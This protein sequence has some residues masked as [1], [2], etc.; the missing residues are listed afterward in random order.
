MTPPHDDDIFVSEPRPFAVSA[1]TAASAAG[2]GEAVGSAAALDEAHHDDAFADDGHDHPHGHHDDYED[3]YEYEELP[4]EGRIPRWVGVLLVFALMAGAV[5]G[6]AW[7]WYQRQVNPPGAPGETVTVVVPTGSSTS[8]IGAILESEG[9]ISNSTIFGFYAGRKDAG[10]F[11]AGTYEMQTNSDFDLALA[12]LAAGPVAPVVAK[13]DKVSI[14]EG[15]TARALLARISSQVP[16]YTAADLD[17]ALADGNVTTTLRPEGQTSWEGMLFPAT[18]EVEDDTSAPNLLNQLADEM[19]VRVAGLDPEAAKATISAR[20]GVQVSTYDLLTVASLVQA[21]AGNADEAAKIATVIYNRLGQGWALGID[22]T[23]KY[24]ADLEGTSIDFDSDSPYN[25]RR[26]QG[27]PPT[28]I[29][30]PGDYALDAAF[31]P[32]EGPWLYYVLTDA[33]THTFAVTEAEF[34]AAKQICIEKGLGCG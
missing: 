25:T 20:Y 10:P 29:A 30:A 32:A 33:R 4:P 5:V 18:Y 28:P 7:W 15:L 11:E 23:S 24:I 13:T 31:R 27:L 21:E 8:G 17:A 19:E 22:A 2:A 34:L 14:P 1:P 26:R 3:H 16:R 6:G 9:V 12:T